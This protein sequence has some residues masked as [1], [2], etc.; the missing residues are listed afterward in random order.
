MGNSVI[1]HCANTNGFTKYIHSQD[2]GAKM[3]AQYWHLNFICGKGHEAGKKSF[4][5]MLNQLKSCYILNSTCDVLN[6][7]ITVCSKDIYK[8]CGQDGYDY[9]YITLATGRCHVNPECKFLQEHCANIWDYAN[10]PSKAEKLHNDAVL[11]QKTND[12]ETSLIARIISGDKK[13]SPQELSSFIQKAVTLLKE[14]NKHSFAP[15]WILRSLTRLSPDFINLVVEE[16]AV[17]ILIKLL[18]S[19]DTDLQEQSILA[20]GNI[21]GTDPDLRDYCIQHGIIDPLTK[22]ISSDSQIRNIRSSAWVIMNILRHKNLSLSNDQ[23]SKLLSA[24]SKLIQHDDFFILTDIFDGILQ[25]VHKNSTNLQLLIDN[26]IVKYVVK[27]LS[28]YN[29]KIQA[30]ALRTAINFV[31]GE[32]D[33]VQYLIDNGVLNSMKD[34]LKNNDNYVFLFLNNLI[35]R[36]HDFIQEVFNAELISLIVKS[37]INDKFETKINS[38]N[39]TFSIVIHGTSNHTIKLIHMNTVLNLCKFLA[40]LKMDNVEEIRTILSTINVIL[41]KHMKYNSEITKQMKDSGDILERLKNHENKHICRLAIAASQ[42]IHN[43]FSLK[44]V[45]RNLNDEF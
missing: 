40:Q 35:T 23:M 44:D 18:E 33:Q 43:T 20:L 4:A 39:V 25:L 6:E 19:T 8:Y 10:A 11:Q 22:I 5:C 14:S 41:Q 24:L 2:K 1:N 30:D 17:P 38:L 29:P 32:K 37:L 34:L 45:I 7:S 9:L 13:I 16:D 26:E 3:A 28:H 31:D 42:S 27:N 12:P 36:Y 15:L 21:I